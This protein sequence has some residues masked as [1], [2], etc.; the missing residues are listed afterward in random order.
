M[1]YITRVRISQLSTAGRLGRPKRP[2]L[3]RKVAGV[4]L[5]PAAT[6]HR[7]ITQLSSGINLRLRQP[8]TVPGVA[9]ACMLAQ[10]P[11]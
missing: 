1:Q 11:P 10:P 2:S 5:I 4:S 9:T 7:A 3:A 6:V 8:R